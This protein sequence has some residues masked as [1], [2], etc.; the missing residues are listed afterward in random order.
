[1]GDLAIGCAAPE[2]AQGGLQRA[3]PGLLLAQSALALAA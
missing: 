1:V 3:Q 2:I